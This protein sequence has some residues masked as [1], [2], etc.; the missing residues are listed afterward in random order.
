MIHRFS[1]RQ[2]DAD[3]LA[4]LKGMIGFSIANEPHFIDRMRIKYGSQL[5]DR[6]LQFQIRR[7]VDHAEPV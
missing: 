2:L 6:I 4:Y 7:D 3:G 1:L 5:I